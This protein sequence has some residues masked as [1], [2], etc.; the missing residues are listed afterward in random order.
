MNDVLFKYLRAYD[1]KISLAFTMGDGV[2]AIRD[3]FQDDTGFRLFF[4]SG[5]EG[6]I[7]IQ[8]FDLWVV[9]NE[10]FE[11]VG[12]S[13]PLV[14]LETAKAT[15]DAPHWFIEPREIDIP[16]IFTA[17]TLNLLGETPADV[18]ALW[19]SLSLF[20]YQSGI[21]TMRATKVYIKRLILLWV[22]FYFYIF[23]L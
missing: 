22:F 2:V 12:S 10:V 13:D 1:L 17:W 19:S 15:V 11:S 23:V 8:G 14:W 16:L 20:V 18:D 4:D 3:E 5:A 6:R 21:Q 7:K 9:E